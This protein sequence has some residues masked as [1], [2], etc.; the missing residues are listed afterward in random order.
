[1]PEVY[2][3]LRVEAAQS[4]F[5]V[6]TVYGFEFCRIK[7]CVYCGKPTRRDAPESACAMHLAQY[8]QE[9]TACFELGISPF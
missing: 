1:M 2:E 7:Q 4:P 6:Y 3:G 9:R 5:S 8:E